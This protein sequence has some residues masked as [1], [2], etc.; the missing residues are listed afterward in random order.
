M[1]RIP[2]LRK[3]F[4][5][6]SHRFLALEPLFRFTAFLRPA[7][8]LFRWPDSLMSGFFFPLFFSGD[9]PLVPAFLFGSNF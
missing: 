9:C 1:R 4:V 6:H 3:L 8:E 7:A 2:F 5:V